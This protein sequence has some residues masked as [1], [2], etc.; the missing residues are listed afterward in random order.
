MDHPTLHLVT[1][2]FLKVTISNPEPIWVQRVQQTRDFT[3][4]H[5]RI[6]KTNA[7]SHFAVQSTRHLNECPIAVSVQF[8]NTQK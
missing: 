4:E 2:S 7:M 6:F 8:F 3:L 1:V 5:S